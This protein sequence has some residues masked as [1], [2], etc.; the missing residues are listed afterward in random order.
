MPIIIDDSVMCRLREISQMTCPIPTGGV[1]HELTRHHTLLFL[2]LGAAQINRGENVVEMRRDCVYYCAPQ[3][4]LHVLPRTVDSVVHRIEFD[5]LVE[6]DNGAFFPLNQI[7]FESC[8][9]LTLTKQMLELVENIYYQWNSPVKKQKLRAQAGIYELFYLIFNEP[10]KDQFDLLDKLEQSRKYMQ[11]HY[12]EEIKVSS[13]ASQLDI[14]TKYYMELFRK[15]YATSAMQYL[16]DL[17]ME[18]ARRMLAGN[19]TA[20]R[21]V[22]K[23]VGYKDEFYFSRRFKQENGVSPTLFMQSRRQRIAVLDSAFIG[24]LLP[25]HYIPH[26]APLHP[27]WRSYYYGEIGDLVSLKLSIGRSDEIIDANI[28]L[29]SQVEDQLDLI[30]YPDYL[31]E[32]QIRRLEQTG[33]ELC[34]VKWSEQPWHEQFIELATKLS[35]LTE[36]NRWLANYQFTVD[37]AKHLLKE[38]LQERSLLFLLIEGNVCFQCNDRGIVETVFGELGLRSAAPILIDDK[39]P[40]SIEQLLEINPDC[41]MLLIYQDEETMNYWRSLQLDESWAELRAVRTGHV[42]SL[43]PFP[44]RD[45]APLSIDLMIK[46]LMERLLSAYRP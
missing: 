22:A 39:I 8:I 24:L 35:S 16:T 15:F 10:V 4:T 1:A 23:E 31:N 37:I 44:W 5:W 20:I 13:L 26:A 30:L 6:R 3:T 36:A 41:L 11:T 33:A 17:R 18:A 12:R 9:K 25:I 21:A 45:Y 2:Q 38:K 29:L 34:L 40:L 14:S 32:R 7:N 43:L 19:K 28:K 42:H 27:V 46:E